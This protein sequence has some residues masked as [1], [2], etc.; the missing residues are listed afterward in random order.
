[1][2]ISDAYP[3]R[4]VNM[5]DNLMRQGQEE[6]RS[7]NE[8]QEAERYIDFLSGNFWNKNRP[9]Y[10]S[11]FYDNFLSEARTN[12]LAALSDI[13]PMMDVT[14]RVKAYKQQ[15]EVIQKY[16]RCLWYENDL[17]LTL[18]SWIDHSLF[19]SG[20][21]KSTAFE[22]NPASDSNN[23]QFSSHGLDFVIPVGMN[24]DIQ[25][26]GAVCYRAYKPLSYFQQRFGPAK[27]IGLQREATA[28]SKSMSGDQYAR[29]D[30]IPEYTWNAMGPSLRRRA[31][32]RLGPRKGSASASYSPF[33]VIE[34]Q[35][36]YIDDPETNE[37]GRE[38]LV[39]HPDLPVELHNFHYRVPPNWPLYPR[40]R[41]VIFAG[42]RVMYDGPSPYWH[43]MFPFTLLQ[44]NP[45]VWNP[46]GISAYRDLV[47]LVQ[48]MNRIG[49]G[50]DEAV[51]RA[52]NGTWVFKRGHVPEAVF[53]AFIPGK[54]GQKL[55][56]NPVA[57]ASSVREMTAPNLPGQVEFWAKYL[58]DRIRQRQPVI[59]MQ[60]LARKKQLPSGE[61]QEQMRDTMSG[62][63]RLESRYI[64]AALKQAARQTVSNIIQ[65]AT[66]DERLKYL[67]DDGWTMQDFDYSPKMLSPHAGQKEDH[68]KRFSVTVRQGTQHGAARQQKKVEAF[69]MAKAG[70]LSGEGL[71]EQTQF[72]ASWEVE[73][74]RIQEEHKQGFGQQ[75][76]GRQERQT[77]SQRNGSPI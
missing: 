44:L 13:Q 10:R 61:A 54:P 15:D 46:G 32:M 71:Y 24:S 14:S 39:K 8:F 3:R 37:T 45:C 55:L 1:M 66:L 69:T 29:P 74:K 57:D 40:K 19:G 60:Q 22:P 67:G 17:D 41:L 28:M 11:R 23:F 58:V 25:E 62:P 9:Q 75:P 35:E 50:V 16:M 48:S 26:S 51:M 18:V 36:W 76:K 12:K 21:L 68:W 73:S 64:E 53:D 63:M 72:P 34:L 31:A 49:V 65:Y 7:Y 70:Y 77:R 27:C 47:P 52:L 56:V 5:R 59:D 4:M 42:S 2:D 20:I 38:M 33:P 30:A 43:G 6:L